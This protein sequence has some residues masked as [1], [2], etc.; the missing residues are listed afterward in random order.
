MFGYAGLR[1]RMGIATGDL[2]FGSSPAG[3]A[4]MDRAKSEQQGRG[5]RAWFLFSQYSSSSGGLPT[6]TYPLT[7]NFQLAAYL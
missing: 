7:H 6:T 5:V 4:V 1:V 3:S 2:P